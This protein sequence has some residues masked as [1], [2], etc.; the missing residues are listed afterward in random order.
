MP[1]NRPNPDDL[2]AQT[3]AADAAARR[4]RLKI[5]FGASPGVGKTYAMLTAARTLAARGVDVVVGVVETHGRA[6]TEGQLLGL[7]ILPRRAVEYRGATLQEFDL[8]AALERKPEFIL[9][10]E[11]AH[12]N[13]PGL[14]N[15]KRWQDVR[16]LLD[17]GIHVYSTLNVQHIES[18]NDLVAQITGV[19]VRET[20]PDSVVEQA[21]E[22][23]LV[24]LPP[25]A[26]LERLRQGKVYVPAMAEKAVQSFFRRG[27]LAAL[28]ELALR[29]TAE[30]VDTQVDTLKREQGATQ[31][32]GA[33]ER[34]L[35]GVGP[36]P[37]SATLLRA[38]KRLAM[39]LRADILAVYVEPPV[40]R[41]DAAGRERLLG[42]LRL[43]ES[44]GAETITVGLRPGMTISEQ[45]LV[46]ARERNVSKILVGKPAPRRFLDRLHGSPV[47]RL[48]RQST[49]IDVYVIRSDPDE[50]APAPIWSTLL[51]QPQSSTWPGYVEALAIAAGSL[52]LGWLVFRPP[53]LATEAMICLLGLVC[54]ALRAGRGPALAASFAGVLAFNYLF[55]EPL[56]TLYISNPSDVVTLL[57]ILLVSMVVGS[58]TSRVRENARTA[59]ER[60]R[61]TAALYSMTRELAAA[62]DG[63]DVVE[64]ASR[65]IRETFGCGVAVVLPTSFGGLE[66]APGDPS[67]LTLNESALGVARWCYDHGKPCGAGTAVLPSAQVLAIPLTASRGKVGALVV[68]PGE[69]HNALTAA[70]L[71]LLDTF[72]QQLGLALERTAMMR[73][74]QDARLAAEG[75]RLRST[76]LASVSHDL[77][78]PLAAIAGSASTLRDSN[79][80][81]DEATR[82]EL[83]DSVVEEAQRLNR[84][85]GNLLFATR[86]EAGAVE[87]KREWCSVEEIVGAAVNR[88][89]SALAGRPMRTRLSP[90]L[91]LIRVDAAMLEQALINLLENAARHTPPGTPVEIASFQH[92]GSVV[93]AVEDE[94]PGINPGEE[95]AIFRRFARGSRPGG[96]GSG[97][98]LAICD[99]ILRT[100][101]GRVWAENRPERGV[102]FKMALPI[103]PQPAVPT[104]RSEESAD[105]RP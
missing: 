3:L 18:L 38:A 20:V 57:M 7:D 87:P 30:W 96:E 42:N 46:Y 43:A 66:I 72:A 75:E 37:N 8:D 77:R 65:H 61:R 39:A 28:R 23:E 68:E 12:T 90:D 79:A 51:N 81:L 24:D 35:V 76:L 85:I 82:V 5:F 55:T 88:V 21:D 84:L 15:E 60:E 54:A 45:L 16:A 64:A 93:I 17:A 103:E 86:L 56:Y 49:D 4:G 41:L 100:H 33:S 63:P 91:P 11:L 95:R 53:D 92:E 22:V 101:G 74:S 10:D 47:D 2:L 48:I 59:I 27:N 67:A 70:R 25:D 78:T 34:I 80:G 36:S 32:W 73:E 6:E 71:M 9:V 69:A 26:L 105:A 52:A 98:G 1:D 58:L 102:A 40:D 99:G 104:Q 83:L 94:G 29:R 50:R 97:L 89:E 31:A 19:R 62:R 44:L 13:A 14:A